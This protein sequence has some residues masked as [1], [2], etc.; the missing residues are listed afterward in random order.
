MSNSKHSTS[1]AGEQPEIGIGAEVQAVIS[2]PDLNVG[3]RGKIVGVYRVRLPGGAGESFH[4]DVQVTQGQQRGKVVK[5]IPTFT[6]YRLAPAAHCGWCGAKLAAFVTPG[7]NEVTQLFL[8]EELNKMICP[9]CLAGAAVH[10]GKQDPVAV[11][12]I[13]TRVRKSR[14]GP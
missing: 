2:S 3:D 10:L 1:E 6:L 7:L 4:C 13:G 11:E 9:E 14:R 5:N 12:S 8:L